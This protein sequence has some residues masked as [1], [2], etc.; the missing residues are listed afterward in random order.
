MSHPLA[1][2]PRGD[3]P[4]QRPRLRLRQ[5]AEAAGWCTQFKP[6]VSHTFPGKL[7]CTKINMEKINMEPK[8]HYGWKRKIESE[9]LF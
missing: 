8:N 3:D 7:T 4:H 2:R 9:P 5:G 6:P 1:I